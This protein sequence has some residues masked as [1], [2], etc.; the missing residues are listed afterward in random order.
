MSR[1]FPPF[2]LALLSL[3]SL[4]APILNQTH[5]LVNQAPLNLTFGAPGTIAFIVLLTLPIVLLLMD[6]V[7]HCKAK[8]VLK[9]SEASNRNVVQTQRKRV[10][11]DPLR[12][13]L[14]FVND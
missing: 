9:A 4:S 2:A 10:G 11:S 7:K 14:S 3:L 5:V 8:G 1:M 6:R 13:R 12:N